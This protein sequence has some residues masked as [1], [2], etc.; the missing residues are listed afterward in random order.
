MNAT[1]LTTEYNR[2]TQ[3]LISSINHKLKLLGRTFRP[4]I[5]GDILDLPFIHS[6]VCELFKLQEIRPTGE[7][8]F[9]DD[10]DELESYDAL[11]VV[12]VGIFRISDILEINEQLENLLE[13]RTI[14]TP[15]LTV[16]KGAVAV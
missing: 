8:I 1:Q 11:T 3:K 9:L 4:G 2:F 10:N 14:Y 13:K 16:I 5:N 7:F 12:E 15:K 6:D